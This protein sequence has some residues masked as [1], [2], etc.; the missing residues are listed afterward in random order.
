MSPGKRERGHLSKVI[1]VVL[2]ELWYQLGTTLDILASLIYHSRDRNV[3]VVF[4]G[5]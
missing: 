1:C 3:F 4:K 5:N 2:T